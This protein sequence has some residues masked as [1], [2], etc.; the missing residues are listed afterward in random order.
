M[1]HEFNVSVFYEDTDMAGI[2]YYAN[3]LKFIERGRSTMVR[4]AGIDQVA[5]KDMGIVFAV[6]H[7]E[8][9]YIGAAKLNDDLVVRTRIT[10]LSGAKLTFDQ[11]VC[12]GDDTL[13]S[14]RVL[15]VCLNS[16]G[17]ATRIPAEIR[18][19]LAQ[20]AA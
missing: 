12:C 20:I 13:F 2:V 8:A 18:Q 16:A 6:R 17:A 19:K 11:Q 3:Y 14:A 15:V 7:L 4:D 10:A 5:M 1:T 9:D